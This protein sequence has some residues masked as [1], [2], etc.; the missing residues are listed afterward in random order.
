MLWSDPSSIGLYFSCS[1]TL[2]WDRVN[3]VAFDGCTLATGSGGDTIPSLSAQ[4]STS[5]SCTPGATD[6]TDRQ[7]ISLA[8]GNS[9]T[10]FYLSLTNG[11]GTRVG[12]S[13]GPALGGVCATRDAKVAVE[14]IPTNSPLLQGSGAYSCAGV[15]CPTS[16]QCHFRPCSF[17]SCFPEQPLAVGTTCDDG[18][19]LTASDQ[20]DALG[21]CAGTADFT[22][23]LRFAQGADVWN[24]GVNT[25]LAGF[26]V[27]P[28]QHTHTHTPPPSPP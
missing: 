12:G 5:V 20:C 26:Q 28:P 21:E 11:T 8:A 4:F 22:F 13:G 19:P 17:G 10:Q 14:F 9:A 24:P 25:A 23:T 3:Q 6:P 2:Q 18:N 16:R 27:S 7:P 15:A 1:E